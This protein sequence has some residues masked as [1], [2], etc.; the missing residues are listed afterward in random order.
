VLRCGNATEVRFLRCCWL[1][2]LL[3]VINAKSESL[4]SSCWK[5]IGLQFEYSAPLSRASYRAS[6]GEGR[7]RHQ[8]QQC[9]GYS[10]ILLPVPCRAVSWP[11]G[12]AGWLCV[13]AGWPAWLVIGALRCCTGWQSSTES[14]S[15]RQRRR[16]DAERVACVPD[17][18][19]SCWLLIHAIGLS[20]HKR[21]S[22]VTTAFSSI[23]LYT[24]IY[25]E[26]NLIGACWF[27]NY[28]VYITLTV[29]TKQLIEC[30]CVGV[31]WRLLS[32]G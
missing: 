18:L 27:V 14:S 32:S 24:G 7:P 13:S 21:S 2:W 30:L 17:V 28:V 15:S 29:D 6:T 1:A 8:S 10:L 26:R 16:C 4:R 12:L 20:A 9:L 22:Q 5:R 25:A 23:V 19:L 31:V 3:N 11:A